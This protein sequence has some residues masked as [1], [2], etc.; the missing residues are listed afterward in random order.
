MYTGSREHIQTLDLRTR[1]GITFSLPLAGIASRLFAAIID[2]AVITACIIIVSSVAAFTGFLNIDFAIAF[3]ILMQ[4]LISTGYGIL[5]EWRWNGQT[6]GKRALK[7]QVID[8]KGMQVTFA[9]IT[10]RN[11]LRTVDIMPVFYFV[12]GVCFALSRKNKR[13]GDIA[14]N[15]VVISIAQPVLPDIEH[16]FPEKFNSLRSSKHLIA[17][18]HNKV[19]NRLAYLSLDALLR[20]NEFT[21]QARIRVFQELADLYKSLITIPSEELQNLSDEHFLR[22]IIEILFKSETAQTVQRAGR[23][24]KPR[25]GLQPGV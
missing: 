10:I 3:I 22:D 19:D 25:E 21:P 2:Q 13:L 5:I 14:A 20:R 17:Q 12:G 16:V 6:I 24:F 11:L 7:I 15:T 9:Q 4:F 18:L 23:V 1:E 8:E